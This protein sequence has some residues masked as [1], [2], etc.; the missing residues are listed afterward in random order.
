MKK[1]P[2]WPCFS[3]QIDRKTKFEIVLVKSVSWCY[4]I[5]MGIAPNIVDMVIFQEYTERLQNESSNIN[6]NKDSPLFFLL[7]CIIKS[8]SWHICR[9][10]VPL[11][12]Y[13]MSAPNWTINTFKQG[14]VNKYKLE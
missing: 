4:Q 7:F 12:L 1:L 9:S 5:V 3:S 11:L 13:L 6:R 8:R 2:H 10:V 14:F